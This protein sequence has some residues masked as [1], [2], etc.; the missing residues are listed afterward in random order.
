MK[1]Q[2]LYTEIGNMKN[3]HILYLIKLTNETES[4][5]KIGVT[6]KSI[7]DRMSW[8]EGYNIEI[9]STITSDGYK[10]RGLESILKEQILDF[11]KH[12]QPKT[13]IAGYTECYE[14]KYLPT[15]KSAFTYLEKTLSKDIVKVLPK[16]EMSLGVYGMEFQIGL[17]AQILKNKEFAKKIVPILSPI[18]FND[19]TLK[20]IYG[21]IYEWWV[22]N[23]E[24][25]DLGTLLLSFDLTTV[26]GK[27]ILRTMKKINEVDIT[28]DVVDYEDRALDWCRYQELKKSI[29]YITKLLNRGFYSDLYECEAIM[30][31]Q[32]KLSDFNYYYKQDIEKLTDMFIDER[33]PFSGVKKDLM[34]TLSNDEIKDIDKQFCNRIDW[35]IEKMIINKLKTIKADEYVK[36]KLNELTF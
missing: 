27:I 28:I 25:I 23:D 24:I 18:Y 15:I 22:Q 7:E 31:N 13:K 11:S 6:S 16:E 30:V 32:L 4:F 8:I 33:L 9:I 10:I 2:K 12:H 5:C 34:L 35:E 1:K 14:I 19:E 36:N 29:D 20:I 21:K 3:N 17:I 26:H